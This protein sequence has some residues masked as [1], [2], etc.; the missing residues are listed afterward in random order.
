MNALIGGRIFPN[1]K[2]KMV[3][4]NPSQGIIFCKREKGNKLPDAI[5]NK[6]R[7][8]T[9]AKSLNFPLTKEGK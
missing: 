5:K 7:R 4:P 2:R 6:G 8:K 3:I 1:P 9:K